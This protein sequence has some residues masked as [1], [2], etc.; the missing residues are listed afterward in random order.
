MNCTDVRERIEEWALGELDVEPRRALEEHLASC[1]A[2]R[3]ESERATKTLGML[4]GLPA[5]ETAEARRDRAV[6]AMAREHADAAARILLQPRRRS[7]LWIAAV[8]AAVLVVGLANAGFFLYI[9]PRSFE[10]SVAEVRGKAQFQRDGVWQA[11]MPGA[12]LRA[13]DRLITERETVVALAWDGGRVYVNQNASLAFV[14]GPRIDLERGELF[15]EVT[16]GTLQIRTVGNDALVV[17]GGRFEAGLRE[18]V[19]LVLGSKFE[20]PEP[21]PG[22]DVVFVDK[23]FEEVARELSIITGRQVQA[24]NEE[25]AKRRVWFYGFKRDKLELLEQMERDLLDQGIFFV[26]PTSDTWRAKLEV[27]AE[28]REIAYRLFAK[29]SEGE[30][31]LSSKDGALKL[32]AGEEGFIQHGG[33]PT[34][35][36][37]KVAGPAWT[38]PGYYGKP[39]RMPLPGT[40]AFRVVGRDEHQRPI[41]ECVVEGEELLASLEGETAWITVDRASATGDGEVTVPVRIRFRKKP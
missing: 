1:A 3:A 40:L 21:V 22:A 6:E 14:R 29:I 30:A 17:R 19:A 39:Q 4:R 35:R 31:S 36:S 26:K 18:T 8:A 38:E 24:D 25:V 20:K 41:V 16:S 9:K 32:G 37:W 10:L 34:S 27:I 13:G 11:V 28:R 15:G 33:K 23:P 5:L 7:R 12:R 2:C